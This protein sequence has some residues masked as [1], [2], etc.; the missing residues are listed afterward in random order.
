[1]DGKQVKVSQDRRDE[2]RSIKQTSD[3]LQQTT[4]S[5]LAA[6]PSEWHL[7]F[8]QTGLIPRDGVPT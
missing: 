1:M 6:G 2:R 7:N 8:R 5:K 3:D 4:N